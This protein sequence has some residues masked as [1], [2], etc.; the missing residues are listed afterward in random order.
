MK[1]NGLHPD[2]EKLKQNK[3]L[4]VIFV[5][6]LMCVIAW[7]VV[8]LFNSQKQS[9]I[10]PELKN[11]AIPLVPTIDETVLNDLENEQTFSDD[12]LANFVIYRMVKTEGD[13]TVLLPLGTEPSKNQTKT[14]SPSSTPSATPTPT[15]TPPSENGLQP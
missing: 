11:S 14:S 9:A 7:T 3:Q 10:S 15:P 5:L 4:L 6:L 13:N 8:T 2:L 12:D 1:N